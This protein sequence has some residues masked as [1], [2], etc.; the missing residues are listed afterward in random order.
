MSE[1]NKIL[2]VTPEKPMK[3]CFLC[4]KKV[5][6]EEPWDCAQCDPKPAGWGVGGW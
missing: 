4:G 3:E 6:N 2:E 5:P 1:E